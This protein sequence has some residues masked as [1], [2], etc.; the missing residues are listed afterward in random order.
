ML[1]Q[2]PSPAGPRPWE[3][4]SA[5]AEPIVPIQVCLLGAFRLVRDGRSLDRLITGKLLT[6][7]SALAVRRAGGATREVLLEILWPEQDTNQASVSLHN[8][9]SSL[10]RRLRADQEAPAPIVYDNG[11]YAVN[12]AAGISTDIVQFDALVAAGSMATSSGLNGEAIQQYTKAVALYRGDLM[13]GT[14]VTAIIE[15]ERLRASF[16]SILAWLA[17]TAYQAGAHEEALVH[18]HRLLASDPCREDAHRV[19]MRAHVQRGERTQ[20][21]RQYRLCEQVLH[22]EFDIAP[23]ALTTA[24]FERIR[25]E[26]LGISYQ[27]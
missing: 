9:I 15:R 5:T 20:A 26:S 23:E 7:L 18:A 6:L 4:I 19:V 24:L 17:D 14:D 25:N 10:R 27:L 16:L 11:C 3:S 1:T 12:A 13:A 8:L 2:L 22:S 21:L